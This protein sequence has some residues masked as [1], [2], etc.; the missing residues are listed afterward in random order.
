MPARWG[1]SLRARVGVSGIQDGDS[2]PEVVF[3]GR[4]APWGLGVAC[5][6]KLIGFGGNENCRRRRCSNQR[7]NGKSCWK[8]KITDRLKTWGGFITRDVGEKQRERG[9]TFGPHKVSEREGVGETV[10][11]SS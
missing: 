10:L 5:E 7:G 1:G 6:A 11:R 4:G 9:T 8:R 2:V 3:G